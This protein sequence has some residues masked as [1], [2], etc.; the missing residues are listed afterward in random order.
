MKKLLASVGL[1]MCC[2]VLPQQEAK[3]QDPIMEI[4]KQA[5][6]KVIKAVD[7][8][9]QRLQNKTIWLQNAQKTLENKMSQLKL[10]EI[11][12]WVEKQ[13]KLYDD[14]FQELRQVKTV[15]AYYQRV[16]D[17][18]QRQVQ[19][20][21]EYKGAWALFR[22]DKNFTKEELDY[23]FNIYAGMME[24]SGK[25]VDQLFLVVNAFITQMTD[26]KRLEI[27][28]TVADNMEQQYV[29]I[30]DFNNQNKM[31]SLQ[32]AVAKG[33]IEYVRRLY[34]LGL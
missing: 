27:I 34:G 19:I 29:D 21:A 24:E 1:I 8:K 28:N 12:D 25:N 3:A 23:M 18:V 14:Y 32:R 13:R 11:K 17:I 26:A 9:I 31:I 15:L 30:K 33:E 5:V 4:I 10:D 7:L 6:I 16:K 22:Q 2:L 20:V